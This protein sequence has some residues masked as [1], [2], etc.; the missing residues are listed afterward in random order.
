MVMIP[1]W[2]LKSLNL[3][4]LIKKTVSIFTQNAFHAIARWKLMSAKLLF[5]PFHY[6]ILTVYIYHF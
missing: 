1:L 3:E 2:V 6:I 4:H 5:L